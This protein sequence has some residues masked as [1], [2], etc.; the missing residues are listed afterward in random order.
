MKDYI[1]SHFLKIHNKSEMSNKRFINKTSI[2][3]N[4]SCTDRKGV[5]SPSSPIDIPNPTHRSYLTNEKHN[6]ERHRFEMA[7]HNM[8]QRIMLHRLNLNKAP[9]PLVFGKIDHNNASRIKPCD[10]DHKSDEYEYDTDTD[11]FHIDI[12]E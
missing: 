6:P 4:T 9:I 11:I 2:H 12:D 1:W 3:P 7:T 10:C 8:Y 5:S